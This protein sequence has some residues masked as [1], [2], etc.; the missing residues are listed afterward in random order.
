MRA[1]IKIV[2]GFRIGTT[3]C[4][5]EATTD[6]PSFAAALAAFIV[7][8]DLHGVVDFL[9][10]E[11]VIGA[12][13]VLLSHPPRYRHQRHNPSHYRSLEKRS[14]VALCILCGCFRRAHCPQC[15]C[16]AL[17]QLALEVRDVLL[18]PLAEVLKLHRSGHKGL[19]D[20][21]RA[22]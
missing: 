18:L 10:R 11:T 13:K 19:G 22:R 6:D 15:V 5:L 4:V 20:L 1:R 2:V 17:P 7:R 16:G 21:V 14:P 8:A 3:A 9:D 12:H